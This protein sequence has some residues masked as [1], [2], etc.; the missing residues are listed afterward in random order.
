MWLFKLRTKIIFE[1]EIAK[2]LNSTHNVTYSEVIDV[3]F[4]ESIIT[5][6]GNKHSSE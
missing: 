1:I 3:L 2:Y 6:G 4:K 5:Y